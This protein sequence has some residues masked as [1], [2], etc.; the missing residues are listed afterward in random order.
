MDWQTAFNVALGIVMF[1][2]GALTTVI[3]DA[4]K[5]LREDLQ[6]LAETVNHNQQEVSNI[7]M[8]RDDFS[9][10]VKR[11]EDA[12]NRGFDQLR[13]DLAS[14]ANRGEK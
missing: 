11:L 14:K 9:S 2:M 3:W 6:A 7:Y 8:R 1:L 10:S 13:T 12:M 5:K 4:L